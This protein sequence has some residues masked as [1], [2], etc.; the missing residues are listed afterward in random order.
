MNT[1]QSSAWFV[2]T[3]NQLTILVS[4]EVS[5]MYRNTSGILFGCDQKAIV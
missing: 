1:L 3:K 5:G 4:F 2:R